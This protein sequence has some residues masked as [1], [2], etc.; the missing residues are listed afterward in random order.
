MTQGRREAW[1]FVA[2]AL[3]GMAIFGVATGVLMA[4]GA[5]LL[6]DRLPELTCLQVAFTAERLEQVLARFSATERQAIAVLLKPGDM[7][8]AW[9]YGL[10]FSGLLGLLTRCL[11][12]AWQR[13]GGWLM[14]APLG[15]SALD[16]I[17]DL[18]LHAVVTVPAGADP[19]L[20]PLV[21]GLAASA[22]YLLLSVVAPLYGLAGSVAGLRADRS[23]VALLVY[24]LVAMNAVAFAARPLQQIPPCF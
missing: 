20:L 22:K 12:A 19:G 2:M 21:A 6:G 8:F 4:P 1:M 9:G 17:E 18:C 11:P 15:A 24:A 5:E 3:A 7:V 13:A 23:P 16:C 14:W 10:L